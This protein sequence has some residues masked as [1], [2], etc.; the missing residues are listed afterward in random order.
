MTQKIATKKQNRVFDLIFFLRCD[1][2]TPIDEPPQ[3]EKRI[4]VN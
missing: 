1:T 3:D 4:V 2:L